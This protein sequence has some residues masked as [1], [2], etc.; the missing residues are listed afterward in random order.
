MKCASFGSA[1]L[2]GLFNV[3]VGVASAAPPETL[4]LGDL[5]NH[6]DRWPATVTIPKDLRFGNGAVLHAGDKATVMDFDGSQV[7]LT[8]PPNLRFKAPAQ[9]CGFLDA[10]NQAWAALTVAQRA[11][12]STSLAND[13]SLWPEKVALPGG[14]SC[15]FGRLPQGA[16]VALLNVTDKGPE[17]AWPNSANRVSTDFPSTDVITRA[18][19]LALLDPGKRPSRIVAA[20]EKVLVDSDGK[21]YH[22]DHLQN[23]KIFALYFGASWCPPCRAFSPDFVKY[24]NDTMPKHPELAVVMMSNDQQPDKM[25]EYM[26]EEK[27]P[28]PAVP[29]RDLNQ[30]SLLLSYSAQLIPELFIVDRF[31]KV[32]ASNDDHRGGRVDPKDTLAAL[33]RILSAPS[34]G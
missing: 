19:Q 33:N 8:A 34:P 23:K 5:V 16:E 6:P 30:S 22:D 3:A 12:D 7:Y 2:I 11:V 27:M 4:S 14:I 29:L 31:G 13:P 9:A 21:P 10:A 17:I 25:L 28:F 32:L 15:N 18:R 1:L 20:L 26:K 24:L